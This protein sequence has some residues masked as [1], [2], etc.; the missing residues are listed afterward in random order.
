[1]NIFNCEI[2][3]SALLDTNS[4][5]RNMQ[6]RNEDKI[7]KE[8]IFYVGCRYGVADIFHNGFGCA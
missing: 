6:R 3:V 7:E 2:C 5:M 4:F 1:M 8:K